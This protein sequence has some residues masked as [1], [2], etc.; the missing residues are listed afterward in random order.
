MVTLEG[1]DINARYIRLTREGENW[2]SI[3]EL[4]VYGK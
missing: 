3:Y 4:A 1:L 2:F